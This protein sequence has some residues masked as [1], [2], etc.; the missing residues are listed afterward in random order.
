M[1]VTEPYIP[2][3]AYFARYEQDETCNIDWPSLL[4]Q[5]WI[6]E[7]YVLIKS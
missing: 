3:K 2:I 7:P 4:L 6:M 1:W 5:I